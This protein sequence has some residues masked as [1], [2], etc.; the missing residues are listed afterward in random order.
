[1][2]W[3]LHDLVIEGVTNDAVVEAN[4]Q[5]SFGSLPQPAEAAAALRIELTLV[6]SVPAPPSGE[7]QFRQGDVLHYFVAGEQ[8]TAHFPRFGQLQLDL[9]TGITRGR[10]IQPAIDTY[11]VLEDLIAIGLSPHLRRRGQFLIHAFA[12]AYQGQ[13][14][15][16]VGGIGAGKT[17]TGISLLN[18]GW[19]LLSNDSPILTAEGLVRRYPGV[20]AAY[21]ETFARFPTTAH[22]AQTPISK[23]GRKKITL[24]AEAIWPTVWLDQ[25][26]VRLILFPQIENRADHELERLSAPAALTRLLPHAVEQWDRPLIPRHLAL[27]RHLV[28]QAPAYLLHLSPDVLAIPERLRGRLGDWEIERLRD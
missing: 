22:L 4:W 26:P 23:A 10:I 12:A 8:V 17:T 15:L 1:M 11:G 27:L 9:A 21:P 16:I 6:E 3:H 28:E 14:V 19:Q 2:K 25:A 20:L 24:P 7:P 13:G 18:A 5:A